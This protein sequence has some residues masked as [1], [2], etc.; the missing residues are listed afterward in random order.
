VMKNSEW[1]LQLRPVNNPK[2]SPGS[3]ET[4][5]SVLGDGLKSASLN[6]LI[7]GAR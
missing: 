7:S 5:E 4:V 6:Q 3:V 2:D 1:S